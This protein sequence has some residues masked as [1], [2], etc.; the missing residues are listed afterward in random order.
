[1]G[2]KRDSEGMNPTDTP[3]QSNQPRVLR[4]ISLIPG[5]HLRELCRLLGL[6]FTSTRYH[7]D[8]LCTTGEIVCE[9]GR[10][11]V[12]LFPAGLDLEDKVTYSFLRTKRFR[13]ILMSLAQ[14]PNLT[15][16][17]ICA[18]T[19]LP[20]S[21]VSK[22]I[23]ALMEA[24]LVRDQPSTTEGTITYQIRDP[25]Y[26]FRLLINAH[27]SATSPR[28]KPRPGLLSDSFEDSLDI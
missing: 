24:G 19:K 2:A 23:H 15:N 10:G 1:M 8:K 18:Q 28:G 22:C 11:H 21:T 25:E 27:K 4:L 5:I 9:R 6:S 13:D 26:L 12:R 16:K 7:V 3:S 17:E 14:V 20:K